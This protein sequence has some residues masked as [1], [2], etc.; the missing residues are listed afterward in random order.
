MEQLA[1]VD[2]ESGLLKGDVT[3]GQIEYAIKGVSASTLKMN[4]VIQL[5]E[6]ICGKQVYTKKDLEEQKQDYH[7]KMK[8]RNH[9]Q[10][11]ARNSF[12]KKQKELAD[13]I[14]A[15]NRVGMNILVKYDPQDI[16]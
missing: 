10:K 9:I 12:S 15:K 11:I 7:K 3:V 8:T 6:K 14:E 13:R 4:Q 5:A 1:K 2:N 16:F